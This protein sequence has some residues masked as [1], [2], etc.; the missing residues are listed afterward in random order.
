MRD[1]AIDIARRG[2]ARALARDGWQWPSLCAAVIVAR[3]RL[4]LDPVA[5][6]SALGVPR[7]TVALLEGGGCAPLL[8]PPRL[9][10]VV[11]DIDWAA[12][13]VPVRARAP[14]SEPTGR[15]PA[16]H[17]TGRVLVPSGD[18]CGASMG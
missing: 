18:V 4:G 16:G 3:G 11:P 9:A 15:H 8:A 6:A 12:L 2:L 5:F 14:T 7:T 1:G 10:D 17:R 13:G